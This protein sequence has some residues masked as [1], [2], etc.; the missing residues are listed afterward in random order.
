[1]RLAERHQLIQHPLLPV[2]RLLPVL[3][4]L[5]PLRLYVHI[6]DFKQLPDVKRIHVVLGQLVQPQ[7]DLPCADSTEL[8]PRLLKVINEAVV[9]VDGLE[10]FLVLLAVV[11]K[12]SSSKS[13]C[14]IILPPSPSRK[15]ALQTAFRHICCVTS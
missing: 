7:L 13:S 11:E 4:G 8:V 9:L 3:P 10:I 1:M 12:S 2:I 5:A 6:L 15:S 14:F